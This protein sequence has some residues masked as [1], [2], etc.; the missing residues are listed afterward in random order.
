MALTPP[1]IIPVFPLYGTI[2]LPGCILPLNIFEPRYRQMIKDHRESENAY[3]GMIQPKDANTEELYKIGCIGQLEQCKQL[4]NGN[5]MIRLEGSIRFQVEKEI[6]T[7]KLY[8]ET[9]VR[10]TDF[11]HDTKEKNAVLEKGP[12]YDAFQYYLEKRNVTMIWDKIKMIPLHHLVNIL[13]MNLEFTS[14]EKQ[15]LLESYDISTRW[16]D[17]ISLLQMVSMPHTMGKNA[18]EMLN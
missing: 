11:Q 7:D 3:I 8:R 4:P 18:D 6:P 1:T 9:L 13:S 12:L 2:L 10:Y 17:L 15:T 14:S 5:Y 16:Q